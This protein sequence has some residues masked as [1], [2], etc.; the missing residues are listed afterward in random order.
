MITSTD[1]TEIK[2]EREEIE[3]KHGVVVIR[4]F[5]KVPPKEF[6]D[7]MVKE[8][9]TY[10]VVTNPSFIENALVA[11]SRGQ[12]HGPS[13]RSLNSMLDGL[14][15]GYKLALGPCKP[16]SITYTQKVLRKPYAGHTEEEVREMLGVVRWA[17]IPEQ[18]FFKP[19]TITEEFATLEEANVRYSELFNMDVWPRPEVSASTHRV[20]YNKDKSIWF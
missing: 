5:T 12:L 7:L 18:A 9:A 19:K 15:L 4:T 6:Q 3:A 14:E 11:E 20:N 10:S 1:E 16:Y 8:A 13:C 2:M 17:N